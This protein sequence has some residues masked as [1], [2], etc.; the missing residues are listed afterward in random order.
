MSGYGPSNGAVPNGIYQAHAPAPSAGFY[1]SYVPP[2]PP[3]QVDSLCTQ[4]RSAMK[5]LGAGTL[6]K[7]NEQKKKKKKFE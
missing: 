5:G 1:P 4:L 7:K 3:Q 2:L 6:H